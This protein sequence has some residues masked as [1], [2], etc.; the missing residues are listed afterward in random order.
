MKKFSIKWVLGCSIILLSHWPLCAAEIL[1]DDYG[2]GLNSRWEEK[3]FSNY[4][5][6]LVN[7]MA[8]NWWKFSLSGF[9]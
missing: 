3:S 8:N 4:L 2:E 5:T 7:G 9:P 1:L 6:V